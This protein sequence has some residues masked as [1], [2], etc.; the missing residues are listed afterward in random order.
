MLRQPPS[1][2]GF[3]MIVATIGTALMVAVKDRQ[4]LPLCAAKGHTA[5]RACPLL[6]QALA[7]SFGRLLAT[8]LASPFGMRESS[9][10]SVSGGTNRT[11][12]G[13]LCP[14]RQSTHA[15][16]PDKLG[17]SLKQH[18][19]HHHLPRSEDATKMPCPGFRHRKACFSSPPRVS[20][21]PISK[22]SNYKIA[23]SRPAT[24]FCDRSLSP[25]DS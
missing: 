5:T 23:S 7:P 15:A 17:S 12:S 16:T 25:L 11:N 19:Q 6:K 22:D 21:V 10:P 4:S 9:R 1:P 20:V 2:T 24:L 13:H 18:R 3:G 14:T 8:P